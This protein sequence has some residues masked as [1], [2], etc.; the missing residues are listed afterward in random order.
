MGR[1]V[2]ACKSDEEGEKATWHV[3]RLL[4]LLASHGQAGWEC[5][6]LRR[7]QICDHCLEVVSTRIFEKQKASWRW[8]IFEYF[9]YAGQM[10]AAVHVKIIK[11]TKLTTIHLALKKLWNSFRGRCYIAWKK[12]SSEKN[13]NKLIMNFSISDWF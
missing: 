11:L 13:F 10:M 4:S 12:R 2:L 6:T 1:V 3:T 8:K 5:E 7:F 9:L